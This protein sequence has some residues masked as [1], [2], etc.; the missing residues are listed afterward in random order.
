MVLFENKAHLKIKER[1]VVVR[2]VPLSLLRF[3]GLFDIASRTVQNCPHAGR[4]VP[5]ALRQNSIASNKCNTKIY[6][7]RLFAAHL[8][9]SILQLL[10]VIP[11]IAP[12]RARGRRPRRAVDERFYLKTKKSGQDIK[13]CPDRSF[14]VPTGSDRAVRK[15]GILRIPR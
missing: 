3:R 8:N 2:I 10:E 11:I 14:S 6:V 5:R 9:S 7:I 13:L 4:A 15:S 1:F 12:P